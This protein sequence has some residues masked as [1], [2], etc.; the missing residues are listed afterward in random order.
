M[1]RHL[2]ICLVVLPLVS[3]CAS[4]GGGSAAFRRD[5]GNASQLDAW[6][7]SMKVVHQFHYEVYLQDSIPDIRIE[8]HWRPRRP[9]ADE[10]ALGV[11]DAES[12]LVITARQRGQSELGGIWNINLAIDNRIKVAGGTEWNE[13]TNT[14]QFRSYADDIFQTFRREIANIGVRRY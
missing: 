4:G 13:T 11:T 1:K 12:R 10:F 9:F 6:D 8:T 5:V 7:L 14:P 3:A 2:L